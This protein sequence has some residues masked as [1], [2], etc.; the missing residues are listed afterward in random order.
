MLTAALALTIDVAWAE[1][2][3]PQASL[4]RA[5]QRYTDG[6]AAGARGELQ[7]LL[8][9]GP[10]LPPEVRREALLWLGDILYAEGGSGAARNVFE[11]LLTEAP[12]YVIDPVAHAPEV[13]SYFEEVRR[14]LAPP[15]LAAPAPALPTRLE[16]PPFPWRAAVPFGIGY[17]LDG[18]HAA[19]ASIGGLQLVGFGLSVALYVDLAN[20]YPAGG[21]FPEGAQDDLDAFYWEATLNQIAFTTGALAYVVPLSVET[22]VW[23]GR[24]RMALGVS[25]GGLVV[26]GRF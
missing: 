8:A 23:A 13:V 12:T 19:G 21:K 2:D 25:P 4:S 3:A 6:D 15:P 16:P 11:A 5:V 20:N 14:A 26:S 9:R 17:F 18:K 7:A 1:E 24:P 10:A 22:G